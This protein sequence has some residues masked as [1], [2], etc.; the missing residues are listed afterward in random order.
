MKRCQYKSSFS[1]LSPQNNTNLKRKNL[2]V[3]LN[4]KLNLKQRLLVI[5]QDQYVTDRPRSSIGALA[6]PRHLQML[7]HHCDLPVAKSRKETMQSAISPDTQ[8][9][10]L[11]RQ[12]C[13]L[14]VRDRIRHFLPTKQLPPSYNPR[15]RCHYDLPT[16]ARKPVSFP[17]TD[18]HFLTPKP[19]NG[20]RHST[21]LLC[22]N[23]SNISSA[24]SNSQSR[25]FLE[26]LSEALSTA[27]PVWVALGCLMGL[28]KP[29]SF[30]WVTPPVVYLGVDDY[31]VGY[32]H[33]PHLR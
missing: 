10:P 13:L 23:S 26:S 33:D 31:Y 19:A 11:H 5:F 2:Y 32:G 18:R 27:F 22:G 8:S 6:A 25:G 7:L 21:H 9:V 28:W 30:N 1:S 20:V 17:A 29:N 24:T 3:V 12:H 16:E 14:L 4:L 15:L